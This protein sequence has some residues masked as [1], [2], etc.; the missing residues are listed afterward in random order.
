M[1][2]LQREALHGCPS[3]PRHHHRRPRRPSSAGVVRFARNSG[4]RCRSI[5]CDTGLTQSQ[6]AEFAD[7]S[8]KDVG[9]IERGEANTTL[10][11]IEKLAG[12]M[13]WNPMDALDGAREPITEGIR[14]H[15]LTGIQRTRG[16]FVDME[17]WLHALDPLKH[18]N[19]RLTPTTTTAPPQKRVR[20]RVRPSKRRKPEPAAG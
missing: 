16:Q 8:L 15:L 19:A 9:E 1:L 14:Q 10:E 3:R 2:R 5:G 6:L 12:A 4:S 17:D 11:A 20:S 13:D 7:L 18:P